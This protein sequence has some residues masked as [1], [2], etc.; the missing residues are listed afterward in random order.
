MVG[1]NAAM[2]GLLL[3]DT[4]LPT[5]LL[6]M[7]E[8]CANTAL[9]TETLSVRTLLR[10]HW[11]CGIIEPRLVKEMKG[12]ERRVCHPSLAPLSRAAAR[13]LSVVT[14]ER[15]SRKTQHRQTPTGC[16]SE[17]LTQSATSTWKDTVKQLDQIMC[18]HKK[19]TLATYEKLCYAVHRV[20]W[21]LTATCSN[22]IS[23]N[24]SSLCIGKFTSQKMPAFLTYCLFLSIRQVKNKSMVSCLWTH[25][26]WGRGRPVIIESV[27]L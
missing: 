20:P 13:W 22:K 24:V 5:P 4:V 25:P 10:L 16:I 7:L 8:Q 1:T 19:S 26:G 23:K 27:C 11:V 9:D 18:H 3:K 21:R 6:L 15:P 12:N 2:E 14:A 17:L